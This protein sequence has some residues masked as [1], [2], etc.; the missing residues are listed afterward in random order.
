MNAAKLCKTVFNG[1]TDAKRITQEGNCGKTWFRIYIHMII[2]SLRYDICAQEYCNERLYE[3]K[4]RKLK[5]T[6]K[7][8]YI[9]NKSIRDW[10]TLYFS[11]LRFLAKWSKMRFS[12]KT[13]LSYLRSKAYMRH[14][15]LKYRPTIQYG[16]KIFCEHKCFGQLEIGKD[17][18][19]GRDVDIDYTSNLTIGEG[20]LLSENVKILTHNHSYFDG[21]DD[22]G[23]VLTPLIIED[24]VFMGARVLVLPGV[25]EIG[26]GALLSAG[27]VVRKKVPPY[28]IVTGN[29]SMVVGFRFTPDQIVEYEEDNYSPEDRLPLE[30]LEQNYKKFYIERLTEIK[31]FLK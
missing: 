11:N 9:N 15:R 24:H 31:D 30:L 8:L 1:I 10:D 26:R 19:I 23:I 5:S 27:T 2:L 12:S 28:S 14:Y 29:P 17:V 4:G 21:E 20:T 6:C 3:L 18:F 7:E 13:Y 25:G 22:H 16:V